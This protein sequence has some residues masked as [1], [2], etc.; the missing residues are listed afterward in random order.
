MLQQVW[1]ADVEKGTSPREFIIGNKNYNGVQHVGDKLTFALMGHGSG[2]IAPTADVTIEGC[3][4]INQ[5]ART[6]TSTASHGTTLPGASPLPTT[7]EGEFS[8]YPSCYAS[9][10]NNVSGLIHQW[11]HRRG[12]EINEI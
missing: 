3:G 11:K 4:G 8:Q 5:T 10:N 1:T 6:T 2:D 7:G 12:M 9:Q